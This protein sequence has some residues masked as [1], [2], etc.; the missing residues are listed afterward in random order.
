M[1]GNTIQDT[2]FWRKEYPTGNLRSVDWIVNQQ[3]I[4]FNKRD[5][6]FQLNCAPNRDGLMDDNVVARLAEV[7]KAWTKPAPMDS[8]PTSWLNW[9][10][11]A[12]PQAKSI[13]LKQTNENG[14]YKK[15][16]K[17]KVTYYSK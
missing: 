3:I 13:V 6:V 12:L 4:P 16:D 11:P 9:P 2:W 5:V 17:I 7:G 8:I 1:G 15:G 14:I 10:V